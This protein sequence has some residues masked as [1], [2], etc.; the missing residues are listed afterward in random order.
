M[1]SNDGPEYVLQDIYQ[2][3][4]RFAGERH[5]ENNQTVKGTKLPYVVHLSNVAMEILLAA[6]HS[7]N[8]DLEFALPVALLHDT[9][10]DTSVTFKELKEK[11]GDEIAEAVLALSKDERLPK[12]EQIPD[13]IKRIKKLRREVFAV[14][15][16]D[17]ITNLQP[18]PADWGREMIVK[19]RDD[20]IFILKEMQEGNS[21]LAERLRTKIVEYS[22]Y[23]K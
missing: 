4:I 22:N 16:A 17:R 14:K 6:T 5:L 20:S 7:E 8:F 21:Y 13:S 11:F 23:F 10:E 9:I 1:K 12:E 3:A 2:K 19:Y 18:P 15:L